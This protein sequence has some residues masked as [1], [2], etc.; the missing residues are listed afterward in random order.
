[1][2][3]VS[4]CRQISHRFEILTSPLTRGL[5][6]TQQSSNARCGFNASDEEQTTPR[7]KVCLKSVAVKNSTTDLFQHLQKHHPPEWQQCV[8]ERTAQE[9]A[10]KATPP[11]TPKQVTLPVSFSRDVQYAKTEKRWENITDAIA[12]HIA[13]DMVPN[14][15]Y[16]FYFFKLYLIL[17]NNVGGWYLLDIHRIP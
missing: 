6:Y 16:K 14:Q 3:I 17:K 11:P 1:M 12:F 4:L 15:G 8:S 7:C 9:N 13:R 10:D 5:N 2:I